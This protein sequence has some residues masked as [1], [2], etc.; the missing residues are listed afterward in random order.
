MSYLP[1]VQTAPSLNVQQDA[2]FQK[3]FIVQDATQTNIDVTSAN[4]FHFTVDNP[5][6]NGSAPN[7]FDSSSACTGGNGTITLALT[8]ADTIALQIANW[9]YTLEVQPASGD[10]Y[11]VVAQGNFN[12]IAA[13]RWSGGP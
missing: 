2:A 7:V 12:L 1:I 9:R 8:A 6:G 11:Q 13:S 4:A 3:V 5:N 10:D